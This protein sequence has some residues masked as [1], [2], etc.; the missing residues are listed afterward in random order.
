VGV[1]ITLSLLGTQQRK[2]ARERKRTSHNRDI[3]IRA[4]NSDRN[5]HNQVFMRGRKIKAN[6]PGIWD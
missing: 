6:M 2:V 1:G 4:C 5:V 3:G